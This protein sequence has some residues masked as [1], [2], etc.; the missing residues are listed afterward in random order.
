MDRRTF[1]ETLAGGLLAAPLGAETQQAA[2]VKRIGYLDQGSAA[3]GWSYVD[4]LRQG[5]RDLGW[6]EG[7]NIVIDVRFAEGK[8]DQLPR[9]RLSSSA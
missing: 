5:L 8:T 3:P 7:R 4:G 9:S 2:K 6:V 1:L